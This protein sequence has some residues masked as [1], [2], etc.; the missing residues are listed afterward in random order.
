MGILLFFWGNPVPSKI[1]WD[2]PNGPLTKLL[3]LL[4]VLLQI[5]WTC[6]C[7]AA[8]CQCSEFWSCGDRPDGGDPF[9][10][11]VSL[12]SLDPPAEPT[13]LGKD[14]SVELTELTPLRGVRILELGGGK[15]FNKDVMLLGPANIYI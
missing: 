13:H 1:E 8:L 3:E 11:R 6:G 5:S 14:A 15:I 12:D 10:V 9:L 2:L 7:Q 4:D